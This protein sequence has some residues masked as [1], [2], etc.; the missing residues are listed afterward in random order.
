MRA[1]LSSDAEC[2]WEQRLLRCSGGRRLIASL[3]AA[4]N[5]PFPERMMNSLISQQFIDTQSAGIAAC[6][7][8]AQ[9]AFE[10]FEKINF[11]TYNKDKA[12][13]ASIF[14]S[15]SVLGRAVLLPC[16]FSTIGMCVC[17][18]RLFLQERSWQWR[19]S[20]GTFLS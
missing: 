4:K 19:F 11:Q 14:S 6:G 8:L 3:H 17:T 7:D 9:S 2:Q 13:R 20:I 18:F 10:G 1:S 15:C 12:W 5:R 16:H